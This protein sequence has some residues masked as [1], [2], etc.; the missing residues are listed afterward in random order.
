VVVAPLDPCRRR[1]LDIVDGLEGVLATPTE[2]TGEL[3]ILARYE[4]RTD[5]DSIE[6]TFTDAAGRN[7]R[8]IGN[9]APIRERIG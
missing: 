7:W 2:A 1:V 6:F 4:G 3:T 9:R 5:V 8:R